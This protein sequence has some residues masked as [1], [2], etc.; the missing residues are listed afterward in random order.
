MPAEFKYITISAKT[1]KL[2]S[3]RSSLNTKI[4]PIETFEMNGYPSISNP[5]FFISYKPDKIVHGIPAIKHKISNS[6]MIFFL[7]A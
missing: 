1:S 5:D 3:F 6:Q 2:L 7:N 4:L